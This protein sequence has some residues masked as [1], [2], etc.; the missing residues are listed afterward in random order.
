MNDIDVTEPENESALRLEIAM[1]LEPRP[2]KHDYRAGEG[3]WGVCVKCNLPYD[4]TDCSLPDL[5]TEP[6]EVLVV[7]MLKRTLALSGGRDRFWRAANKH[8]RSGLGWIGSAKDY[9]VVANGWLDLS[10]AEQAQVLLAVLKATDVDRAL[11]AKDK[12]I[13]ELEAS[14]ARHRAVCKLAYDWFTRD[15]S[16]SPLIS[17]VI[18]QLRDI[19][20]PYTAEGGKPGEKKTPGALGAASGSGAAFSS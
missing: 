11:A 10:S 3:G 16:V 7:Q 20:A 2:W 14:L 5:P 19:V 15:T 13:A 6:M 17:G 1:V 12:R 4:K 9:Y 18:D 8:M